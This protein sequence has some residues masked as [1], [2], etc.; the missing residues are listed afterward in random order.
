MTQFTVG[1]NIGVY[2][3]PTKLIPQA[4]NTFGLFLYISYHVRV[5]IGSNI[6]RLKKAYPHVLCTRK[7]RKMNVRDVKLTPIFV[8][9]V[10]DRIREVLASSPTIIIVLNITKGLFP[11]DAS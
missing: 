9:N 4:K 5:K 11:I 10:I 8:K 7:D 2:G 6:V 3:H 1:R